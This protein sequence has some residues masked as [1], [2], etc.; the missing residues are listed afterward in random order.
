MC[1]FGH[2]NSVVMS[3][4]MSFIFIINCKKNLPEH[5]EWREEEEVPAVVG[6]DGQALDEGGEDDGVLDVFGQA[7]LHVQ[8]QT[9]IEKNT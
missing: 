3:L 5:S 2:P 4:M 8:V 9:R 1:S 6:E 7:V